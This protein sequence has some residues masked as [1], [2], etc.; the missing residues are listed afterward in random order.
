M[1]TKTKLSELAADDLDKIM[2]YYCEELFVP[3]AAANFHN[4]LLKQIEFIDDNP[5]MYPLHHDEKLR[6]E[7]YR[8]VTIGKFLM[9]YLVSKDEAHVDI[10][11]IVYGGRDLT[12][13]L[14]E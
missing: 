7:G 14:D 11:R 13:L 6:A 1:A 4:N 12:D 9:F 8:F 3:Q 2:R 5:M 10:V